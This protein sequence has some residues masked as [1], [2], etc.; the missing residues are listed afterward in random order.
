MSYSTD[1][2]KK[3]K[4]SAKKIYSVFM[5]IFLNLKRY[6]KVNKIYPKKIIF[7]FKWKY[8]G[9]IASWNRK[10]SSNNNIQVSKPEKKRNREIIASPLFLER[11][12]EKKQI[13]EV[14]HQNNMPILE[15]K[16]VIGRPPSIAVGSRVKCAIGILYFLPIMIVRI[17]NPNIAE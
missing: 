5:I 10:R 1:N 9:A 11:T 16:P 17:N 15:I 6:P 3:K 4:E 12:E 2:A 13:A 7:S 14:E 8:F